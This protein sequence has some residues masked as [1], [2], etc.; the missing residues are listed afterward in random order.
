MTRLRIGREPDSDVVLQTPLGSRNHA[1]LVSSGKNHILTDLG[2]SNGTFVNGDRISEASLSEGDQIHFGD[3]AWTFRGE[4]LIRGR[5]VRSRIASPKSIALVGG[6]VT[7]VVI[8]VFALIGLSAPDGDAQVSIETSFSELQNFE[9]INLYAQPAD[10]ESVISKAR[11]STVLVECGFGAGSGFGI[12]LESLGAG[13]GQR[14]VTNA[15]V[16]DACDGTSTRLSVTSNEG[17]RVSAR[18]VSVDYFNDLALLDASLNIPSL[19]LADKPLQGQWSMAIGNPD[20]NLL[21]T[22]T[23]GQITNYFP[24][25]ETEYLTAKHQVMTDTPVNPGNSG[26]PLVD[27]AGR[28]IGVVTWGRVGF[29]NTGFAGGWPLL[30][31]DLVSCRTAGW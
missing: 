1:L 31:A 14:I 2:S 26:G 4:G 13:S 12:E 27:S 18:I 5:A 21:G 20:G 10:L 30:C 16:I 6:A 24:V 7:T 17:R 22:A 29:D 25:F 23:F 11:A 3:E 8:A 19:E 9:E 28:V 15:H